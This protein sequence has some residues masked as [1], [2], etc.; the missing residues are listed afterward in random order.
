MKKLLLCALCAALPLLAACGALDVIGNDSVTAFDE[1]LNVLPAAADGDTWVLTA[2]DGAAAFVWSGDF[3]KTDAYDV[4]LELDA[5]PFTAAGLDPARL[6]AGMAQ[7][8]RLVAGVSLGAQTP[9]PET[10]ASPVLSYG[11]IVTRARTRIGY[12]AAMDHFGVDLDGGFMFEWA[13]DMTANDKDIVFVLDPEVFR[14]AGV[15]V[16]TVEGW[17]LATVETMDEAG[18]PV[19]VEKLLKPFDIG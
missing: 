18:R 14:R 1:M 9:A 19:E 16:G 15:D 13:R 10:S 17:T 12:H 11:Q 6:P 4:W 5:A 3:G 7:G 8:R 2:P